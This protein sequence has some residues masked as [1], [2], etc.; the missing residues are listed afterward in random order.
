M[1]REIEKVKKE[2]QEKMSKKK[3]K[4]KEKD[5]GKEKEKDGDEKKDDDAEDNKAEREKDDK[6][7]FPS[8]NS[9]ISLKY[10]RSSLSPKQTLSPR[11]T[12]LPESMRSI[13]TSHIRVTL[14]GVT[15]VSFPP[16]IQ[17]K[18]TNNKGTS[19]RCALTAS[20]TPK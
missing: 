8:F 9:C 20:A 18:L 4:E 13:S 2:Y 1:E 14:S 15:Y 17:S 7:G 5:K 11:S 12:R 6:V 10:Y 16:S 3:A 19:T